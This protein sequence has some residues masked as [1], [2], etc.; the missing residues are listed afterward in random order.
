MLRRVLVFLRQSARTTAGA[1][2]MSRWLLEA[3]ITSER[4]S[5][6]NAALCLCVVSAGPR[7]AAAQ[8]GFAGKTGNGDWADCPAE[9]DYRSGQIPDAI[10]RAATENGIPGI[11]TGDDRLG[12]IPLGE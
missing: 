6:S 3:G 7:P 11:F 2:K 9:M 5:L 10:K 8:F 12:A 1:A 4:E